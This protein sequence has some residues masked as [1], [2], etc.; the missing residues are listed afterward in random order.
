MDSFYFAF[1]V[2]AILAG[3]V[4]IEFLKENIFKFLNSYIFQ[5][6]KKKKKKR[7]LTSER[8]TAEFFI[9]IKLGYWFIQNRCIAMHAK[10]IAVWRNACI[11]HDAD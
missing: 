3:K 10:L 7:N 4:D 2:F 8:Y 11:L 6:K 5:K 9:Y 1:Y